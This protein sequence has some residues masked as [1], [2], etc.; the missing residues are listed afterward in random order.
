MK[1]HK[2]L[3]WYYTP[4]PSLEDK[5]YYIQQADNNEDNY[6][7]IVEFEANAE[8]IVKACNSHYDLLEGCKWGFKTLEALFEML[9]E[10]KKPITKSLQTA[11]LMMGDA[12]EKAEGE[13]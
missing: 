8:F 12:I 4:S 6:I 5:E 3:P 10:R 13:N 7:G 11:F 9:N 1:K 2:D